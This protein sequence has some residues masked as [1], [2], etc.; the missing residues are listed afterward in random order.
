MCIKETQRSWDGFLL[1]LEKVLRK[2]EVQIMLNAQ[3]GGTSF[4]E[5]WT[6]TADLKMDELFST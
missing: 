2:K 4:V 6:K 3:L 1:F 5:T